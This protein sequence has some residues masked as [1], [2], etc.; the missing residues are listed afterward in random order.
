MEIIVI[1]VLVTGRDFDVPPGHEISEHPS[2]N[3]NENHEK[4]SYIEI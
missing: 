1:K 3:Y 4:W 2:S